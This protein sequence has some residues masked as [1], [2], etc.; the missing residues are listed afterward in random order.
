MFVSCAQRVMATLLVVHLFGRKT[1]RPR[2]LKHV[3]LVSARNDVVMMIGYSMQGQGVGAASWVRGMHA[4]AAD[5]TTCSCE[6]AS[7]SSERR[8]RH[9]RGIHPCHPLQCARRLPY[10][11]AEQ[12]T[13]VASRSIPTQ[14]CVTL[15]ALTHHCLLGSRGC[16]ATSRHLHTRANADGD[17]G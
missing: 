5:T 16:V 15:N 17:H 9:M 14:E 13:A 4:G 7:D 12:T 1:S 11:D 10:G 3:R 6:V 2:R 8:R